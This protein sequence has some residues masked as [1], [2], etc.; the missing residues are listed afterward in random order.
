MS[1]PDE[2]TR[3][4]PCAGIVVWP[5]WGRAFVQHRSSIALRCGTGT[6]LL[7]LGGLGNRL[8][9]SDR[10]GLALRDRNSHA[11]VGKGSE[12]GRTLARRLE[13]GHKRQGHKRF[14]ALSKKAR[15]RT[16]VRLGDHAELP[17]SGLEDPGQTL[18][19]ESARPAAIVTTGPV[20]IRTCDASLAE[21]RVT[22]LISASRAELSTI[23]CC[24]GPCRTRTC[25][26]EI[27]SP[28]SS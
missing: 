2:R 1:S 22:V 4:F 23:R 20:R 16:S 14:A 17:V 27:M 7:R 19:T 6:G 15:V 9:V 26:Q 5:S 13:E 25:D 3:T 12:Q 21:R 10:P 28:R 8:P 18:R 24:G 11:I